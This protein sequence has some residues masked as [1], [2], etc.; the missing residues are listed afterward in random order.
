MGFFKKI[1]D[2]LTS[3]QATVTLKYG[4]SSYATGENFVGILSVS[5][6]EDFDAKEIR[7]EIQCVE[8]AKKMKR[9]YEEALHREIDREYWDSA[10]LFSAKPA[11]NGAMHLNNGFAQ[12]FPFS[13]NI[14]VS[15]PA[16]SRSMDHRVT[17]TVRGVI[18]VNGRPDV[19][20]TTTE[21]QVSP[22]SASPVITEREVVREVVMLPCKYCGGLMQ[23]TE[24]SC[25]RC[26]AKRTV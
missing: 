10:T 23:Q 3:P 24:T 12:E 5:S 26:G 6:W 21:L 18:A 13:I 25:P 14:P 11:L 17:W 22:P 4:K 15:G 2:K 9:V 20:S 7:C 16:S 8:E 19:T 1:K